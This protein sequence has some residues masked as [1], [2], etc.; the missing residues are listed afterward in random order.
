MVKN[1]PAVQ[2]TRFD[3]SFRKMPCRMEWQPTLVFL[4]GEFHWQSLEGYSPQG[5]K[6]SDTTEWLRLSVLKL[7]W[8]LMLLSMILK[9]G[10]FT[11]SNFYLVCSFYWPQIIAGWWSTHVWS[12][13]GK[14]A[15]EME[16][17][18][19]IIFLQK[20]LNMV[21]SLAEFAPNFR[22]KTTCF[23][24]FFGQRFDISKDDSCLQPCFW[25]DMA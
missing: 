17:S 25:S 8:F 22:A 24:I 20:W 10:T 2:E 5:H 18:S 12:W 15:S 3:A 4:P 13:R 23:K 14:N 21:S 16:S 9:W 11:D 7:L 19:A 6:E 1:L